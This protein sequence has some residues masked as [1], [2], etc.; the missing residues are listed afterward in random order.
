MQTLEIGGAQVLQR[1]SP[2]DV[3]RADGHETNNHPTQR[4]HA[5]VKEE[6]DEFQ[7]SSQQLEAELE[8]SLEQKEKQCRDLTATVHQMQLETES[9]YVS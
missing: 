1:V 6:L 2:T 7:E 8:A 3:L 4:S 5:E 9:L